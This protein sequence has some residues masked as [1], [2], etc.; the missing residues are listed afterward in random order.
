MAG[1]SRPSVFGFEGCRRLF[2]ECFHGEKKSKI[3]E[4]EAQNRRTQ[5]EEIAPAREQEKICQQAE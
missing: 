4:A 3:G 2:F 5:Q 1:R